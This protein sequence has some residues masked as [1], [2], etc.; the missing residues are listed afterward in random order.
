MYFIDGCLAD[1]C[2]WGVFLRGGELKPSFLVSLS[3]S[4]LF[5]S[6]F[7]Y[8]DLSQSI[9]HHSHYLLSVLREFAI[10]NTS[11]LR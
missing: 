9:P 5:L 4:C 11:R 8:V 1:S 7:S 3:L 2:D 10:P 6:K